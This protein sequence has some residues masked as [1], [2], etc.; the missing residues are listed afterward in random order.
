MFAGDALKADADC[1]NFTKVRM[2]YV[3]RHDFT[4]LWQ[5]LEERK[6]II[7]LWNDE[8]DDAGMELARQWLDK[9]PVD[10]QMHYWYSLFLLKKNDYQGHFKHMHFSQGLLASITNSGDGLTPDTPIKVISVAE[11][12]FVINSL[13]AKVGNQLLIKNKSGIEV[14]E[15]ECQ[16]GKNI[17]TLYFDVSISMAHTRKMLVP[18]TKQ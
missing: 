2:D 10:G 1:V 11:E 17:F 12:Y 8:M 14:D 9:H 15:M 4:P 16:R 13:S 18:T 3:N 6:K 7:A 5:N